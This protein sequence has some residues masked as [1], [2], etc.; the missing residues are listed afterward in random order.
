MLSDPKLGEP[1]RYNRRTMNLLRPRWLLPIAAAGVLGAGP[2]FAQA[3][4]EGV[5]E[6]ARAAVEEAWNKEVRPFTESALIRIEIQ[7]V[8][9]RNRLAPGQDVYLVHAFA[10]ASWWKTSQHYLL[11]LRSSADGHE[12]LYRFAG[13]SGGGGVSYRLVG[14]GASARHFALE[15]SDRGFEDDT[16][17]VWTILVLL[18]PEIDRFAEVFRELTTYRPPSPHAYASTVS[19]RPAEGPMREIVVRTRLEKAGAEVD[20]VESLFAWQDSGYQGI[21]PLPDAWRAE[22]PS[23]IEK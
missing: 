22:L 7:A 19:Y 1:P 16:T 23:R 14:L 12:L 13:G 9:R 2:A 10:E 17:G 11:L 20:R 5:A 6:T 8:E 4:S 21:L 15:I 3:D 18:L